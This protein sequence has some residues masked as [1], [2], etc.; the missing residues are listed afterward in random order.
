MKFCFFLSKDQCVKEE[1]N[2][3]ALKIMVSA[4]AQYLIEDGMMTLLSNQSCISVNILEDKVLSL[5]KTGKHSVIKS[6]AFHGTVRCFS[7]TVLQQKFL[8]ELFCT[9]VF[10]Y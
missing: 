6:A 5:V 8:L 7:T 1:G 2:V 9:A 10:I 4:H 3:I